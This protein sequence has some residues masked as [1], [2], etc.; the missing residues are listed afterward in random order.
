MALTGYERPLD[1]YSKNELVQIAKYHKI[2]Y[3]SESGVGKL[4]GYEKLTK[5]KLL[6]LIQNDAD[7]NRDDPN[8]S[9]NRFLKFKGSLSGKES[10]EE[11]MD[12]ILSLAQETRRDFPISGKYY[13]HPLIIAGN[14]LPKGFLAFNHHW[15]KIRQYNTVDGD[16][17]VSGLYEITVQE[18]NTLKSVPYGKIIYN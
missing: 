17:L 8:R 1:Q 5:E 12:G 9:N 2:Y 7:Y 6:N 15:G 4:G 16:R 10:P 18:F 11:L 13:R 3:Q 14:M